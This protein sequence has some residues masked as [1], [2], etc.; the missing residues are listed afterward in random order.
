MEK[1][2][3]T[4]VKLTRSILNCQAIL[5]SSNS[6]VQRQKVTLYVQSICRILYMSVPQC[7]TKNR[8]VEIIGYFEAQNCHLGDEKGQHTT[9]SIN[10]HLGHYI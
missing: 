7:V 6:D 9:Y 1:R 5:Y 10:E 4:G 8:I 3:K 2:D